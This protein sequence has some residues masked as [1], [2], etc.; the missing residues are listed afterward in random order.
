MLRHTTRGDG[1]VAASPGSRRRTHRSHPALAPLAF[2]LLAA[3]LVAPLAHATIDK[4]SEPVIARYLEATGGRMAFDNDRSAHMVGQV[5]A[6]GLKG[7]VEGWNQRPDKNA[8]AIQLGP[9]NLRS[10][11]DGTTAWRSDPNGK[12]LTLD[13]KDLEDAR[14]SAWFEAERWLEP[15][16]GGGGVKFV[17]TENDSAGSYRVLEITPPGGRPRRYYF[18]LKS[19]LLVRTVMKNDMQTMTS[20]MSDYRRAGDRLMAF[21]TVQSVSGMAMNNLTLSVDSVWTNVELPP[22]VFAMP[23]AAA[24]ATSPPAWLKTPGRAKLPF[25]YVGRHVW[26]RASVNGGPPADFIYDTGASLT[27]L[28]SAYAAKI[29]LK[30]E[31]QLQGQGAGSNGTGA[32]A[33]LK[34][35]RV[36]G[37]DG[38][39]IEVKDAK[40]AV[41]SVNPELAPFFWRDCAGIIGFDVINQFVNEI[42]YDNKTLT[43]LEP[44]GYAYTGKGAVIPFTLS[45][46]VPVAKFT[47]DDKYEGDYRLDVGS[48]STVDLHGPY[49]EKNGLASLVGPTRTV[50]GGGFGGTFESRLGRMHKMA[51]GPYSWTKPMV[52]LSGATGGALASEDFAGNVGNHIL[53]RFKVTLDYEHRCAYLEPGAKF[54]E[55]DLFSRVG[56]QLAWIDG[57]VQVGQV[58]ADSPAAKAGLEKGDVVT[59]V[60]GQAPMKLG[61]NAVYDAMEKGAVGSKMKFDIERNGKKMKKTVKLAE[62]V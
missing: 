51:I 39:G 32:F 25:E 18:D 33:T 26:L 24:S 49:V 12:I 41:L 7:K 52:L 47:L 5:E 38:D 4:G 8:T 43:L 46:H 31:G 53:E 13:G 44:N 50:T 27:V 62:L 57:K 56:C 9:F 28:D 34:S 22:S 10:G 45:G 15:D 60:D 14:T 36:S 3:P 48:S 54:A 58:L 23:A 61:V 16:Q 40:I 6:F 2:A 59:A 20:T 21:H 29:G 35:L 42:D 19:G 17:G 30:T 1:V 11:Y 37:T 55:A